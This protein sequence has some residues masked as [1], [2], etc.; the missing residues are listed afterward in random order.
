M[1]DVTLEPSFIEKGRDRA[2]RRQSKRGREQQEHYDVEN[3]AIKNA[4]P[5]AAAAPVAAAAPPAAAIAKKGFFSTFAENKILLITTAIVIILFIIF[6]VWTLRKNAK[7][8]GQP[9]PRAPPAHLQQQQQKAPPPPPDDNVGGADAE[10]TT[11]HVQNKEP[12]KPDPKAAPTTK[13][14]KPSA[15]KTKNPDAAHENIVNTVDDDELNAYV[16]MSTKD[17]RADVGATDGDEDDEAEGV[18]ASDG[19]DAEDSGD[20]DD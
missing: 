18:D 19:G 20:V 7:A 13:G 16:N 1:A 4:P 12:P 14:G 8:K 10:A 6:I 3:P 5:A 9:Q 11:E 17:A 2:Q 15:K